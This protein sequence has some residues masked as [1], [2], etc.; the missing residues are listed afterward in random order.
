MFEINDNKKIEIS[1]E[2][3]FGI[4][5]SIFFLILYFFFKINLFFFFLIIFI[6]SAFLFPKLLF[7]PNIIWSK[8][9]ILIGMFISPIILFFIFISVFFPI[10]VLLKILKINLL[11]KDFNKLQ[12]RETYWKDREF[13]I[14][15]NDQF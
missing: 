9:G 7:Y 15:M 5:F 12:S 4:V 3:N 6:I 10:G 11:D 2:K 1:S 13:H 8:L 14:N